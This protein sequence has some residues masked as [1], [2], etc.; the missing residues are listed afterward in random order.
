MNNIKFTKTNVDKA[1][2]AVE[3]IEITIEGTCAHSK[4]HIKGEIKQDGRTFEYKYDE[5]D[6]EDWELLITE[7]IKKGYVPHGTINT[8]RAEIYRESSI[9]DCSNGG[10][11]SKYDSVLIPCLDGN[12][13]VDLENPPENFVLFDRNETFREHR[14]CKPYRDVIE[15]NWVMMGGTF[16]YSSDGRFSRNINQYPIALHDRKE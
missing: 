14:Y 11:S 6:A 5:C 9:G 10:I 16:V 3:N 8:V 13:E 2:N 4:I 7:Y 15:G 12:N 1:K